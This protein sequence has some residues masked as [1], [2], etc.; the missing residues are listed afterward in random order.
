MAQCFSAL[1]AHAMLHVELPAIAHSTHDVSQHSPRSEQRHTHSTQRWLAK[2]RRQRRKRALHLGEGGLACATDRSICTRSRATVSAAPL[3]HPVAALQLGSTAASVSC[4]NSGSAQRTVASRC[5][6][7]RNTQT[8]ANTQ[9][10]IHEPQPDIRLSVRE[11]CPAAT[12][13]MGHCARGTLRYLE[14]LARLRRF[15]CAQRLQ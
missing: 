11:R 4:S 6:T 15:D 12:V 8:S 10:S 14:S 3:A 9:T 2:T 13:W 7:R 1:L 5:P